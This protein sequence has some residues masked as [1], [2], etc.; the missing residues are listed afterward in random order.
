MGLDYRHTFTFVHMSDLLHIV[1]K[2]DDAT[3]RER[4]CLNRM[5][6]LLQYRNGLCIVLNEKLHDV[7]YET[8]FRSSEGVPYSEMSSSNVHGP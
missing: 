8:S 5:M 1:D 2:A 7:T 4:S 6:T 3:V